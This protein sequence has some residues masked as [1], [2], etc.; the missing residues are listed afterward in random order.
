MD[1]ALSEAENVEHEYQNFIREV[2]SKQIA[3]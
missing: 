2:A 1:C 3:E